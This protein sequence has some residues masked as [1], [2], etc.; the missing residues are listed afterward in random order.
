MSFFG[1][2]I[3]SDTETFLIIVIQW[4]PYPFFNSSESLVAISHN[5]RHWF[6]FRF[7]SLLAPQEWELKHSKFASGNQIL[8][9]YLVTVGLCGYHMMI[10]AITH[11]WTPYHT[12]FLIHLLII[13]LP[14]VL[15]EMLLLALIQLEHVI[16]VVKE[17]V[18]EPISAG[19][20]FKVWKSTKVK[21]PS[22][23]FGSGIWTLGYIT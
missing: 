12:Y 16:I 8:A 4:L 2:V 14:W 18:F 10:R 3:C 7:N 6:R 23:G 1:F 17:K 20:I 13:S 21:S 19:G 22:L 9:E 11:M 15:S 5:G